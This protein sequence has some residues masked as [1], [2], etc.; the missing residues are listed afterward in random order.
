M[1]NWFCGNVFALPDNVAR[2][3]FCVPTVIGDNGIAAPPAAIK[4]GGISGE[5][6][7][8]GINRARKDGSII[9]TGNGNIV[10]GGKGA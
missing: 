8:G 6:R 1:A 10:S 7:I 9:V 5:A 2:C 3:S 4:R